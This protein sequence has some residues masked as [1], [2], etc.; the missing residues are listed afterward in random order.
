[1]S[2]L[3]FLR[4][5]LAIAV[6]LVV[7]AAL[8][9]AGGSSEKSSD[10]LSDDLTPEL[11]ALS[12]PEVSFA[13]EG[14]EV[15]PESKLLVDSALGVDLTNQSITMP[16]HK[17]EFKGETVWYIL[18]E[19][20]DFGIANGLDVNFSPKLVNMAVGCAACVQD[21][22]LDGSPTN[23]FGEA[24]VQ[25]QGI[26][27]FSPRREL[28]PGPAAG[29][30]A[31]PPASATPG[32]VGDA[33]YSPFIRIKGSSVIYNAP[34]V[35]TGDGPFDVE[36]HSNTADRVLSIKRPGLAEPGKFSTPLV[37]ILLVRGKEADETIFYLSTEASER[38]AATLERATFVPLLE[39]SAFLGGD[40]FLGAARE[41]IFLFSNGQTGTDNPES[42]GLS[43][44]IADGLNAEDASLKNTDLLEALRENDGDAQNVLGDFPSLADPRHANA[45]S[46]LWDA[47]IGEW[48][49][50]AIDEGL[51]V[52]MTDENRIL[53][54]VAERPDLLTGP[55]GSPYGSVGFVIN[56]PTVAF[57]D[58]APEVAA[59]APIPGGQF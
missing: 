46:P 5:L 18:T 50:K 8:V 28:V 34:I 49:Q 44:L 39:G 52:R 37:E 15:L 38:T 2:R 19:A 43:H 47:Q 59:V 1:M 4:T 42:Q 3:P 11:A 14:H 21:V 24:V 33:Q 58:N 26:P 48:T 17:G 27:D 32:A 57:E 56:C 31:F 45:Y 29:P 20:S 13:P 7:L 35:A 30:G 6:L 55:G 25:F 54:L 16:L 23:K 22:T 51:N 40:D 36:L 9:G 10:G 12:E 41:R 53:N